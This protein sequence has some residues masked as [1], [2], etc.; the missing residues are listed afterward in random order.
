MQDGV[1]KLL[2]EAGMPVKLGAR[3]YRPTLGS[4]GKFDVKLL[5]PQNI[6]EMICSG[7]RDVGFAGH[8]WVQ[9][10]GLDESLVELLDT[11]MDPVSIVV[12]GKSKSLLDDAIAK[13]THIVI[14]SE[15]E[16]LTVDWI[17]AKGLNATFVK[18]FG[19]TECFPP[20]DADIIV[21]NTATGST[22]KANG[23][24]I[25][26]TIAK[27]TTRL[28]CSKTAYADPDKRKALDDLVVLINSVLLARKKALVE[29]NVENQYLEPI[30]PNLPSMRAPTVSQL[31]GGAG[32]SIRIAVDRDAISELLPR[33]KS[34]GATDIMVTSARQIV[35]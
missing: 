32:Y 20:E 27:S 35:K 17:K 9:N 30:L 7:T 1:F 8:D 10:L 14:A 18:S 33:L 6:I 16:K 34:L 23:L 11:K 5:K 15:Y 12:A 21:D 29:F 28:Y 26:D 22:L 31:H 2:E 4:N 25:L 13:S 19:A 3:E 24:E